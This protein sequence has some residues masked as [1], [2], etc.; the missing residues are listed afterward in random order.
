MKIM[1]RK[2]ICKNGVIERTRYAVGDNAQPRG[3]RKKGNTGARKQEAN[4]RSAVKQLSRALNCN[5]DERGLLLTLT[6]SEEGLMQISKQ[7]T[8]PE[9][10]RREADRRL[11][12]WIRRAR[13]V[14]KITFYAAITSDMDGDSGEERRVHSHVVLM[15]QGISLDQLGA[16]WNLGTVDIRH[17]KKQTDLTPVAVYMLR[18]VHREADKKKYH[19]SRG[20][21][22]PQT[23][24][25]QVIVNAPI[26]APAGA[27]ILERSEYAPDTIAQYIRYIPKKRGNKQEADDEKRI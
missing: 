6:Y 16:M 13:R 24:E 23:V 15:A 27:K 1:E 12:Q 17:I 3:K 5:C 19:I 14:A 7:K 26:K 11:M 8:N 10:I 21:E 25:R 2:Y 22:R 18:Q 20:A 9:E 4:F